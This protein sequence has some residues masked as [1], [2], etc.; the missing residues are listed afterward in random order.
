MSEGTGPGDH[1]GSGGGGHA[2]IAPADGGGPGDHPGVTVIHLTGD[3]I[4]DAT[5]I[6]NLLESG[7]QFVFTYTIG[8]STYAVFASAYK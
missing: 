6:E 8:G 7:R 4:G 1:P 2:P 3:V 5:M